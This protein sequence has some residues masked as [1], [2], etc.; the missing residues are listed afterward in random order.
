MP[1]ISSV[2]DIKPSL[3]SVEDVKPKVSSIEDIK[4]KMAKVFG[5]T[6]V[7]SEDWVFNANEPMGLLL[8]LTYVSG[9]S[10]TKAR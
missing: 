5:E 6:E 7:Y 8:T 3:F 2:K 1:N 4:P 9:E 10:G